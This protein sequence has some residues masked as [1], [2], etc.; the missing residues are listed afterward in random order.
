MHKEEQ[1]ATGGPTSLGAISKEGAHPQLSSDMDE[2]T[3][4]YSFDHIFTGSNL[5]VLV[6]KTKSARDGLKT[7][8]TDSV[9][10]KE[11][12]ADDISKKIKLE[13]LSKFLKDTRSSFFTPD[14]PHDDPIIVTDE[15][16]DEEAEK[17]DTHDTSHD[18]PKDISVR[19]SYPD[20]NHLIDLLGTSLKPK[21][22][23][24]LASHNFASRLPTKLKELP[25]KFTELSRE[26]KELKQHV[27][28]M[29]I[30]LPGDLKEIPTKLETFTSTEKLKALD[31]LPRL[32]NKV[33]EILNRFAIMVESTSGAADVPLVGQ[34]TASPT[35][36]RRTPRML[37][38]T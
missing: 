3:K 23:K 34:A 29:E 37:K 33:T 15:S 22:S 20:I 13:D 10:N 2:G 28:D 27:K 12:R 26:I 4:N 7:A 11:S 19:P 5:S 38:Q 9:T 14:S 25:S 17:E 35:E 30:E 16:E 1:Q 18:V 36:G 8:N 24:R 21:L 31:S 6:D 32:L